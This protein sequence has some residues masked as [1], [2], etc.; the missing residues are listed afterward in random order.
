MNGFVS[1]ALRIEAVL[2]MSS[3]KST[4]QCFANS[5]GSLKANAVLHLRCSLE[6]APP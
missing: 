6:K 3:L 5:Q 4:S 1:E 2:L